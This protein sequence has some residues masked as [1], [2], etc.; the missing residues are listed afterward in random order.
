VPRAP[1]QS[2]PVRQS[3]TYVDHEGQAT[4]NPA[5]A[6]HGQIVETDSRGR[7]VRR[8]RFFMAE[9]ELPW[10][11]VNEAAFLLWVLAVFAVVWISIGVILKL[12]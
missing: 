7:P 1:E 8:T 4:D 5:A 6:L 2:E 11:P 12:T 3:P 10:L 9:R